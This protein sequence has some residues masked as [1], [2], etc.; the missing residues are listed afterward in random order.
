MK[1]KKKVVIHIAC[2]V[3]ILAIFLWPHS[4][5]GGTKDNVKSISIVIVKNNFD[6]CFCNYVL[7]RKCCF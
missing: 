1:I 7:R 2:V 4:L 6:Y 5:L 3:A